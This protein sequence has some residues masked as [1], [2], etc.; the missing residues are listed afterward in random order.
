VPA[1]VDVV[2][3]GS[4]AAGL[5]AALTAGASGLDVVVLERASLV[6]GSTVLAGGGMWVPANRWM[7]ADG[8][9]DSD[10]SAL[11]Y[12][13]ATVGDG[14]P[15]ATRER[16]TAFVQTVREAVAFLEGQ[17]LRFRR[18][19]GY[20]DYHP[21][22]PGASAAGRAIESVVVDAR[23]LGD[24]AARL[25][26]RRFPR[27]LPMGTLDV[28]DV[29]LA[30]R[31]LRGARRFARILSHHGIARLRHQRLIAGGGALE[32]QLLLAV[33]RREIPVHVESPVTELVVEDGAV[34]GAVALRDGERVTIRA[35]RGVMLAAGGF[36]RND[37]LRRAYQPQPTSA[38]WS[39][40][41]ATDLGDGLRLAQSVG[42]ELA[43]LDEAWWGPAA[44]L[45]GGTAI[46]LVSERAKPG[47]I[48]V[49]AS[50]SRYMNEAQSYVTAVHAMYER[51]RDVPAIPSWLVF[52]HTYRSRYAFGAFL[53]GRMP[54]EVLASGF[55]KRADSLAGLAAAA[56]I[57][58]DGL[59]ATIARFNE[60]AGRG[61]DED[62]GRGGDSYD[63]YY[64][65]PRVKPNPNLAPIARPPFYAVEI[66]P[67]DLG[68]KGGVV[69]D[70]DGRALRPG[71]GVI[72]GLY[73]SGNSSASV[74]G[75]SYPGPGCTLAPA[76]TF[77]YRAMRHAASSV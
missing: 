64:G 58:V 27:S 1:D 4:G 23:E 67:G 73:A 35:R 61:V 21:D 3:I 56:G 68:T 38:T 71:G 75:R 12:L 50:G 31:T 59:A 55:C 11:E 63:M 43:L 6:G 53:P 34:R 18:T 44:I 60:L 16:R 14:G 36:A 25:P 29:L 62:F 41:S 40:A 66:V 20:P 8:D 7:L 47:S 46:F 77:S 15:S 39:S 37:D 32:V 13:D 9:M 19:T 28:A 49:D 70:A 24:W 54:A 17:G 51:N 33:L 26:P 72:E 69:T 5:S 74:M 42:A 76:V 45:P 65:D 52:D 10:E 57:D 48:V 22:L 30:R 2:V